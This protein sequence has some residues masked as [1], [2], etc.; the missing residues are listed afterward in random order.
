MC[1]CEFEGHP[2][3]AGIDAVLGMVRYPNVEPRDRWRCAV[4]MALATASMWSRNLDNLHQMARVINTSIFI[5][6]A[7]QTLEREGYFVYDR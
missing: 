3:V 2:F 6:C 5:K 7:R 4:S 1:L